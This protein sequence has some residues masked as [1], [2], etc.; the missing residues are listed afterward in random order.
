[1]GGGR[2]AGAAGARRADLLTGMSDVPLDLS[3]CQRWCPRLAR[4]SFHTLGMW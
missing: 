2:A 3:V 4:Y 1:V